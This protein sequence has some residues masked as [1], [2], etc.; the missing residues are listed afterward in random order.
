MS[1]TDLVEELKLRR[2]ARLNYSVPDQRDWSLHPVALHEMDQIDEERSQ[3]LAR[4]AES[5]TT[6]NPGIERIAVPSEFVPLRRADTGHTELGRQP[7]SVTTEQHKAETPGV[8][9]FYV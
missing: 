4:I 1:K 8:S 3:Q 9:E 5:D 7:F 2:W 6:L